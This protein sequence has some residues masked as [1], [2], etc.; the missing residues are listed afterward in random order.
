MNLAVLGNVC[1][2][3]N[4]T[5]DLSYE[6][7]GGPPNFLSLFL[8]QAKDTLFT[9]ISS[10]GADFLP[11]KE[12]LNLYPLSPNIA[13]TLLYENITIDGKRSQKCHFY[14]KALPPEINQKMT[15]ILNATDVLF[16]APLIPYFPPKYIKN[17]IGLT[18]K[19]CLKIFLPQGYFRQFDENDNVIFREFKEANEILPLVDFV[20][21]SSEDYPDIENLS[22]TW[23][24]QY[25]TAFILTEAEKGAKIINKDGKIVVPTIP[26]PPSE[27]IDSVGA[28]EIFTASFAYN[29]CK[30]KDVEKSVKLAN[31]SAREKLLAKTEAIQNNLC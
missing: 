4:R 23:S 8:S 3:H 10:Y 21:L 27:I 24:K 19:G 15:K 14:K 7:R 26:I 22:V 20:I 6:A 16:I 29:Y 11:F 18:S 12:D 9:T 2:D 13:N 5:D 17:V 31:E 1:I 30:N 25:N 28:G